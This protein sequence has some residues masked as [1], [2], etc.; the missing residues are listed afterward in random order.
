[1][2]PYSFKAIFIALA[3][4]LVAAQ[5]PFT[6]P[7]PIGRYTKRSTL[8]DGVTF[9]ESVSYLYLDEKDSARLELASSRIVN[10]NIDFTVKFW[11][12]LAE[13]TNGQVQFWS[14][15]EGVVCN[16]DNGRKI[17]CDS[18]NRQRLVADL[19]FIGIGKWYYFSM[20]V[21][22]DGHATLTIWDTVGAL[23]YDVSTEFFVQQ[24]MARGYNICFGRC[25]L[26]FKG[27]NHGFKGGI[28]EVT[29]LSEH[30]SQADIF[31]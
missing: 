25:D 24:S 9:D 31:A 2:R 14:L 13:I 21:T 27:R 4:T 20:A 16:I 15:P 29:C 26:D 18:T 10:T 7:P 5:Q 8:F 12:K 3:A 19:E 22:A 17:S 28:R 11:F 30:Q 23:A 6:R 1:M